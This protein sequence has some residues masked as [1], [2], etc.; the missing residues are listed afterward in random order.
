M[1]KEINLEDSI[2]LQLTV[3][4]SSRPPLPLLSLYLSLSLSISLPLFPGKSDAK[5]VDEKQ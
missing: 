2:V 1:V 3:Y 5:M 4:L